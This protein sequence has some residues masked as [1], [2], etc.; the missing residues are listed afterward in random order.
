LS[1][2]DPVPRAAGA[3]FGEAATL[4][5]ANLERQKRSGYA[6]G[7]FPAIPQGQPCQSCGAEIAVKREPFGREPDIERRWVGASCLKK[8]KR[9]DRLFWLE[10]LKDPARESHERWKHV[11]PKKHVPFDFNVLAGKHDLGLIVADADGTGRLIKQLAAERRPADDWKKF[12]DGLAKLSR[13]VVIDS[14]DDVLLDS[15]LADTESLLLPVLPLFCGGDDIVIACRGDLAL[16][17]ASFMCQ[18]F[19]ESE[20]PWL[21]SG[22]KLS[23][24]ASAVVTRPGFPFRIAHRLASVLLRAAKLEGKRLGWRDEGI[25][26]IDYALITESMADLETI[27]QDRV[28]QDKRR[29]L[30]ISFTGR[31]YKAASRG[32]RSIGSLAEAVRRLNESDFPRSKVHELRSLFALPTWLVRAAAE[33]AELSINDVNE[34]R[35]A[36]ELRFA[37]WLAR[38]EKQTQWAELLQVLNQ[39]LGLTPAT[40]SALGCWYSRTETNPKR[41]VYRTPL[42]DL[43]DGRRLFGTVDKLTNGEPE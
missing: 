38:T 12:S 6:Y 9:R 26:A 40:R 36:I 42:G 17:L 14:I 5:F 18:R 13:D 24:S 15:F 20:K 37:D 11:Q 22:T 29:R 7:Q 32:E 35:S 31:P 3:E 21:P 30:S 16:P 39:V 28:L 1:V 8:Y 33:D 19:A 34:V 23:L 2:S 4:A 43:A 41:G 25:G 27:V 10:W